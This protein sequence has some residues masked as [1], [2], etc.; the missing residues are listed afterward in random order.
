MQAHVGWGEGQ[1]E[2]EKERENLKQASTLSIEPDLG[3]DLLTLS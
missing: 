2:R 1:N 3:L